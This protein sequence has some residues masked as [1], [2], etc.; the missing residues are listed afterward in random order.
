[1]DALFEKIHH[2]R[3]EG[4]DM[5]LVT[6]IEKEGEGPVEVGKKMLVFEDGTSF[7]TVGGGALEL[8]A[9]KKAKSIFS[10]R[11]PLTEKYVLEQG[12]I[13]DN[14][15]TLPMICGGSVTF[16]YDFIGVKNHVHLFGAGHVGQ[17]LAKVLKPLN[18]HITV[19]DDRPN[20]LE[21]FTEANQK[22]LGPFVEHID[23]GGIKAGHYVIV[24]TPSHR[25]DYHVLNRLLES[26]IAVG[27]MG[28]LCSPSKLRD[29]LDKTRET[30]GSDVDLRGFYSP[31]GL[32]LGGGSPEEIA[33]SIAAELLAVHHGKTTIRHMRELLDADDRYW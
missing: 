16:F 3:L 15:K 30:F 6:A 14:A 9:Q 33:I 32:D 11:Q 19:I 13:V 1:M 29:Y 7:G 23:K 25:Y 4:R 12:K 10:S 21:N 27:Y 8:F 24:C 20:V 28:M 26:K 18:F 17:A 2:A 31:I 22:V 5:V